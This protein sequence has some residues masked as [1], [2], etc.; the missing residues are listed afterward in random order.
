[1]LT[2]IKQYVMRDFAVQMDAPSKVSL[3][4]YDNKCFVV[5]SFL[6]APA[7]VTVSVTG[8]SSKLRNLATGRWWKATLR[9]QGAPGAGRMG[10]RAP[11]FTSRRPAQ[12]C[13]V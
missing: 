6:E 5:E 13:G 12:L 7:Q 2:A 9:H 8:S 10:R 3:F 4:A 11:S 1:V